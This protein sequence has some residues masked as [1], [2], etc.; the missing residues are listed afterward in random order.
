M[1]G[2]GGVEGVGGYE[3]RSTVMMVMVTV[4]MMV[5]VVVVVIVTITPPHLAMTLIKHM[6]LAGFERI[7]RL[8]MGVGE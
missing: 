8:R 4:M 6:V 3:R 7:E 2:V 5:M 1:G